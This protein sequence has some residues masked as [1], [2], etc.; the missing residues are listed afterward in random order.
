MSIW[1]GIRRLWARHDDHLAAE[2]LHREA[3][4]V[5]GVPAVGDEAAVPEASGQGPFPHDSVHSV[6]AEDEVEGR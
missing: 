5:G 6:E 2:E 1:S 3:A 4:G